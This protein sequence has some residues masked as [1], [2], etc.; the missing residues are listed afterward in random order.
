MSKEGD[1]A[2]KVA[3]GTLVVSAI[4]ALEAYGKSSFLRD[5]SEH[6][7][8]CKCFGCAMARLDSAVHALRIMMG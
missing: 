8:T 3:A 4:E 6:P 5:T 1:E 7:H 2:R